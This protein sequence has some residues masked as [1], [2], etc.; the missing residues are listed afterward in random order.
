VLVKTIAV[1]IC[2]T[3]KAFYTDIYKLFK[4]PLV[5]GHEVIR[6]V[7]KPLSLQGKNG[8]ARDKLLVLAMRG[9]QGGALHSLPPQE[10]PR[11]RF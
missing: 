3:G 11:D 6:E 5:P 9:L 2:G 10:D 7:V 8:R 1:G 4:S